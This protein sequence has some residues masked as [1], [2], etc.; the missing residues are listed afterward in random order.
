MAK[1]T[2]A[3]RKKIPASKFALPASK[4]YPVQDKSHAGN[5]KARA[6]QMENK[7]VISSSTKAKIFAAA[8]KVLGNGASKK[9]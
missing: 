8:N 1:L 9:K 5:A 3:S 4:K 7:G 6:S 2:A